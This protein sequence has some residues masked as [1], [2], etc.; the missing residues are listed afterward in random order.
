[1]L[2]NILN[3][4]TFLCKN[5]AS[6]TRLTFGNWINVTSPSTRNQIS[7]FGRN[8]ALLHTSST[9]QLADKSVNSGYK[10]YRDKHARS[11][12]IKGMEAERFTD[13]DSGKVS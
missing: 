12:L 13:L 7:D 8:S 9:W 4:G 6:N 1:M 5:C 11:V 2:K 10:Q 3:I